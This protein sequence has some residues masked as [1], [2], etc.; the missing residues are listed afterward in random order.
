[1]DC[2][3]FNY[4]IC[5]VDICRISFYNFYSGEKEWE[6][7]YILTKG[8]A[9]EG[10]TD[11]YDIKLILHSKYL[12]VL[13]SNNLCI[14]IQTA[15]INGDFSSQTAISKTKLLWKYKGMLEYKDCLGL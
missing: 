9:E 3:V 8:H 10:L 14:V 5:Y 13:N 1:M 11:E 15:Q 7:S 12:T 2:G 4:I 6:R